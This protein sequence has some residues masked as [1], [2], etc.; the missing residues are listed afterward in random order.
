M[1]SKFLRFHII[2][3]VFLETSN[4]FGMHGS[5]YERQ[6]TEGELILSSRNDDEGTARQ[7]DHT[8]DQISNVQHKILCQ[9]QR[10]WNNLNESQ[11]TI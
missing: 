8:L 9:N 5:I 4:T 7:G 6:L 1:S 11:E 3:T 10:F 2:G